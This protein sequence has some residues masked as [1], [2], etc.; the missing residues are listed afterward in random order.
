LFLDDERA[1]VKAL[2]S[3]CSGLNIK[4]TLLKI[5]EGRSLLIPTLHLL[6]Q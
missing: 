6:Y 3:Y 1:I 4:D 5:C 2:S